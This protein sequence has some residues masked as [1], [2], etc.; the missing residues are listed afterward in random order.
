MIKI[1]DAQSIEA[2]NLQISELINSSVNCAEGECKQERGFND[3]ERDA[4]IYIYFG[5]NAS[6]KYYKSV[7]SYL[8]SA[9][10]FISAGSKDNLENVLMSLIITHIGH[11]IGMA[12]YDT[13]FGTS[14]REDLV[15]IAE[16][17]FIK[18]LA[19]YNLNRAVKL[20]KEIYKKLSDPNY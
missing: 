5:Q 12:N 14:S 13:L 17:C 2:E 6:S 20:Q 9:N 16:D 18:C 4:M 11:K 15:S 1:L 19:T 8:K 3:E 7:K 10:G